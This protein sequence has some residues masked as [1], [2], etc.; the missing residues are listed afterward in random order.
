[1]T[2]AVRD[3]R[4]SRAIAFAFALA[5]GLSGVPSAALASL[6]FEPV[7]CDTECAGSFG[8]D[9]C[10][11][12]CSEGL[13]AKVVSGVPAAVVTSGAP[14][15]TDASAPSM[16]SSAPETCSASAIFHPPRR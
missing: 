1:M 16:T 14:D 10:P 2:R 7:A 15:L 4:A 9:S 8:E 6:G 13:C 11:P 5:L 12:A 3:R